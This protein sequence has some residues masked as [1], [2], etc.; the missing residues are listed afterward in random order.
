MSSQD[1]GRPR[2]L[3]AERAVL[4]AIFIENTA[5]LRVVGLVRA[6]D[7]YLER[8]RK[9][10]TLMVML[11]ESSQPI[12]MVVL[13]D[14]ARQEG[15]FEE[16]GG[17]LYL[18]SLVNDVPL[19]TNIG[20]YAGIVRERAVLRR[21]MDACLR[22]S[23]AIQDGENLSAVLP[24]LEAAREEALG[25]VGGQGLRPVAEDLAEA[26]QAIE[27][28][29]V[30]KGGITGL[31]TGLPHLDRLLGGLQP[32]QLYVLGARPSMGKSA[33]GMN[34]AFSTQNEIARQ[35]F[36]QY[37]DTRTI[38]FFPTLEAAWASLG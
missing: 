14:L 19:T 8:H 3:E 2:D 22:A 23:E 24:H 34:I 18:S 21:L 10:Y 4:G 7:F 17:L 25:H 32:S 27:R 28:M 30:T 15:I 29:Q 13:A 11:S 33:L 16:V 26:F 12:D 31:P 35:F 5:L 1:K 20:R 6:E 9:I 38:F 36:Q 37:E